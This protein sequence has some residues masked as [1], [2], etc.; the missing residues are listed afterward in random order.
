MICYENIVDITL[1]KKL[2]KRKKKKKKKHS[3]M[4]TVLKLLKTTNLFHILSYK[5]DS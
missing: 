3:N 1:K 4:L 2:S 5:S